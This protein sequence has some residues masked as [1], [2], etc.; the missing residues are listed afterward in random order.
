MTPPVTQP[1]RD[2]LR[3]AEW[4]QRQHDYYLDQASKLAA[5]PTGGDWRKAKSRD[6]GLRNLRAEAMRFLSIA[7]ALRRKAERAPA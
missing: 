7:E 6:L 2:L 1:K 5:S 3:K 4:A